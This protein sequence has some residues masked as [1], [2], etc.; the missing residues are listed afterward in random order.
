MV[1]TAPERTVDGRDGVVAQDGPKD[2]VVVGVFAEG[3]AR[4]DYVVR[5]ERGA[6]QKGRVERP[7]VDVED[8]G[9]AVL[10]TQMGNS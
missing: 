9:E 2:D 6:N 3:K 4:V 5:F 1:D 10:L 7:D 8:L